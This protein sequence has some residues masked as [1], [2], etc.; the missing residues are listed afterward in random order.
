VKKSKEHQ[1]DKGIADLMVE[2]N[3]RVRLLRA[4]RE[5]TADKSSALTLR[6]ELLIEIIGLKE[7]SSVSSIRASY[8]SATLSSISSSI[9]ELWKKKLVEKHVNP[10]DQRLTM[11]KLS[12]NGKKVLTS[13]K[14]SQKNV[15]GKVTESLNL[16]GEQEIL[17]RDLLIHSINYFDQYLDLKLK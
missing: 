16:T 13:I 11:V 2:L 3:L 5:S 14:K 4:S 8:P 1:M 12:E 7:Q 10:D 9:T 6:E 17:V 15:L